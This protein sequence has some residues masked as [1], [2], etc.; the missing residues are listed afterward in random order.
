M[1][2]TKIE[3]TN[4]RNHKNL[5]LSEIGPVLI[6]AGKNAT[7][8]T[9]TI[10]ALQLL[11]MHESFRRPR[12]EE[13]VSNDC[14]PEDPC[15][16]SIDII[17]NNTLNTKQIV[18]KDNTRTYFYN[19]K[20]RPGRELEDLVLAVLFTPD[21]LQ[22]IKG[23]PEQRRDLLDSL[24]KRLSKSFAHIRDE[25]YR[26]LR[27][28]NSLLK[29]EEIDLD[30]LESWNVNLAKLGTSLS[31]HRRGLFEQL[32]Q[33][34]LQAYESVS[35]GED[36]YGGYITNYEDLS[37]DLAQNREAELRAGRSLIGPHKDDI[38]FVVNGFDARRFASQGQQRSLALALKI[39]ETEIL[40]K[41]SGKTPLLL[42]DDV[43]SELDTERR[44][45]FVD[46][47]GKSAQTVLTTTN[48]GYFDREF[49]E[50]ATIVELKDTGSGASLGG[51]W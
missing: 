21:D 28:K 16:I 49:L 22:I 38:A 33:V 18:F 31:K 35:G 45:H 12:F 47:I 29:Q 7:G 30:L 43:M 8:K 13:L 11:S 37:W 40:L 41:V 10:E 9:N 27:H 15:S 39:A 4:F 46:L 44:G 23:P 5:V 14:L 50:R 2:I 32:L 36:L 26:A 17:E 6:I 20:E 1:Q 34:S 48:L 24:G 51:L 25:Y 19:K 3:L 42:L